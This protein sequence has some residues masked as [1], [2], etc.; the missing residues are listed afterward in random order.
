MKPDA[1]AIAMEIRLLEQQNKTKQL[2]VEAQREANRA[3]EFRLKMKFKE[4]ELQVRTDE[5]ELD[6][7]RL[8]RILEAAKK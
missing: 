5:K 7:Q 6:L 2:D 8:L 3:E 1:G 4:K